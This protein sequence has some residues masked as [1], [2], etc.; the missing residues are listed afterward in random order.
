[1]ESAWTKTK[2][3]YT[4]VKYTLMKYTDIGVAMDQDKN[5]VHFYAQRGSML[6]H[7]RAVKPATGCSESWQKDTWK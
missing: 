2:M 6:G 5:E 7:K 4:D 3:K 1:M